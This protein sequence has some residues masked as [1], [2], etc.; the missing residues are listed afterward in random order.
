M[1]MPRLFHLPA[2]APC[3]FSGLQSPFSLQMLTSLFSAPKFSY[4]PTVPFHFFF[5][6]LDFML[7]SRHLLIALIYFDTLMRWIFLLRLRLMS[8]YACTLRISR[9]CAYWCWLSAPIDIYWCRAIVWLRAIILLLLIRCYSYF[10]S[11]Y[12]ALSFFTLIV[13]LAIVNINMPI[14]TFL[15]FKDYF[16]FTYYWFHMYV[17]YA[18]R[19]SI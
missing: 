2:P 17:F 3:P 7:F 11:Y 6:C 12:Y 9:A 19:R 16:S 14:F 4:F 1:A 15:I 8:I 5:L 18:R 13:C 10:F